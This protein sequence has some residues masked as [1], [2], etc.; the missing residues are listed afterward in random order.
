MPQTRQPP[1]VNGADGADGTAVVRI[2]RGRPTAD[3]IAALTAV[4]LARAAALGAAPSGPA[5]P[6][7]TAG[8][9][10]PER[11]AV[12]RDPRGWHTAGGPHGRTPTGKDLSP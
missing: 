3:D 1:A 6:R 9:R 5:R 7:P 10:R 4:L 2:L 11:V 8:W 12:H